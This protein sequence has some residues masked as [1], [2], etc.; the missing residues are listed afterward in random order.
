MARTPSTMLPLGTAMPDAILP[1][2]AGQMH[3]LH[4]CVGAKGTLVLFICNHCPFVLHIADFLKPLAEELESLGVGCV[5][6]N[7]NDVEQY[8]DD[9]PEKMVDF[10]AHYGLQF[11][12]L[13]DDSQE[14]A[15]AYDAACTPDFFLFNAAG[16]L[17]YRGQLDDSRPGNNL[18]VD[19]ADLLAA[20]RALSSGREIDPEQR[21]SLGCNIKW[22]HAG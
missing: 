14:T 3:R 22:K 11:P 10:S 13:F 7:A 1:D 19:G 5:A 16:E 9:A 21:P 8:P 12:Y 18:P 2:G 15:H 4:E 17:V 6:I 20:A